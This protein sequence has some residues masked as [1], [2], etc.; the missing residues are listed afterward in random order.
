MVNNLYQEAQ[1]DDWHGQI[2]AKEL[3]AVLHFKKGIRPTALEM[4]TLDT[5]Q[6]IINSPESIAEVDLRMKNLF[7][8]GTTH[9]EYYKDLG[10]N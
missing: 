3:M 10:A 6:A 4:D 5:L 7:I 2:V 9:P 8:Y 1:R